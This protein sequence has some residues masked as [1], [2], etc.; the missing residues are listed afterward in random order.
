M[1]TK[2]NINKDKNN[3]LITFSNDSNN[4]NNILLNQNNIFSSFVLPSELLI[5]N[6]IQTE[7]KS[8]FFNQDIKKEYQ[9]KYFN[10][11]KIFTISNSRRNI[12]YKAKQP[13]KKIYNNDTEIK[14]EKHQTKLIKEMKYIFTNNNKTN[15]RNNN[16]HKYD[17]IKKKFLN[18]IKDGN[19]IFIQNTKEDK[20][21]KINKYSNI[22]KYHE[23]NTTR[24]LNNTKQ[25]LNYNYNINNNKKDSKKNNYQI[26]IL[27]N[28]YDKERKFINNLNLK[29]NIKPEIYKYNTIDANN[30]NKKQL[31]IKDN[32]CASS[33]K[34][35][36]NI[37]KL[38][39]LRISE[40]KKINKNTK[41]SEL[42][43]DEN[44]LK[45]LS[46]KKTFIEKNNSLKFKNILND[47][48]INEEENEKKDSKSQS[49]SKSKNKK[50]YYPYFL[51]SYGKGRN[52]HITNKRKILIRNNKKANYS[53]IY[54]GKNSSNNNIVL[55]AQK[56]KKEQITNN[57]NKVEEYKNKSKSN[58]KSNKKIYKNIILKGK[59]AISAKST[60]SDIS[61]KES[62]KNINNKNTKKLKNK[63][64]NINIKLK[65]INSNIIEN[66]KNENNYI[67]DIK[68]NYINFI[69][70]EDLNF[71]LNESENINPV[72]II[73]TNNFDVNKPKEKNLKYTLLKEFEDEEENK[74]INKSQIE[75]IVI[76]IIEG[77]T[78]I[79]ENDKLNKKHQLRS[80]SSFDGEKQIT[81]KLIKTKNNKDI[82]HLKNTSNKKLSLVNMHILDD[83]SSEIEDLDFDSNDYGINNHLINLENEYEFE[84]M[85]TFEKEIKINN[86]DNLLPFYVSKIS[87]CKNYDKDDGNYKINENVDNDILSLE[88]INKELNILNDKYNYNNY[89][90]H[91]MLNDNDNNL[92]HKNIKKNKNTN[93]NKNII[94]NNRVKKSPYKK[95]NQLKTEYCSRNNINNNF[96]NTYLNYKNP[97]YNTNKKNNYTKNNV[98]NTNINTNNNNIIKK[99]LNKKQN[100]NNIYND[101]E[102]TKKKFIKTSTNS[103]NYKDKNDLK[104]VS[105]Y[106]NKENCFII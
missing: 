69:D 6:N 2:N 7:Y 53:N 101:N 57:K 54:I 11:D 10:K 92:K 65:S 70:N 66:N 28:S 4:S 27:K 49:K 95:N 86:E 55:E 98:L 90:N 29:G 77:Y 34:K 44:D 9:S 103:I 16:N 50:I 64:I 97:P 61:K 81:K 72:N 12:P 88:K 37:N 30:N 20:Y 74:N 15:N 85:P 39:K 63:N 59:S 75:N 36:S 40:K 43:L 19:S 35:E 5:N 89:K 8:S 96:L 1:R 99:K 26:K 41:I 52:K 46:K 21:N 68:N 14:N 91:S 106:G 82:K 84:D 73:K 71:V 78:D 51:E 100:Y 93:I 105:N 47:K 17:A 67:N 31:I 80:K 48:T 45:I 42:T 23:N 13:T 58:S 102:S 3:K 60:I 94:N 22:I 32:T 24:A 33:T 62:E 87:F 18:K 76:G 38:K 104:I 79:L 56:S 25:N 83:N